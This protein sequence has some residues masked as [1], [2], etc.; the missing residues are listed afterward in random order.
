MSYR[1]KDWNAQTISQV[2]VDFWCENPTEERAK[3]VSCQLVEAGADALLM[4]LLKMTSI[5]SEVLEE[6]SGE[7]H[8][9][10]VLPSNE[11]ESYDHLGKGTWMF[12]PDE[13]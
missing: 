8:Q 2:A 11:V 13:E 5:R 1:P 9:F 12:I 4:G 7:H 6:L 3:H 10:V